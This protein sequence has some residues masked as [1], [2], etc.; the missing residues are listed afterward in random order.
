MVRSASRD[1][2]ERCQ[3]TTG[4][5]PP[6]RSIVA[7]TFQMKHV[8]ST[9]VSHDQDAV[10]IR[11]G[12]AAD[13]RWIC[14]MVLH[15]K[16][17]PIAPI[18]MDGFLLAVDAKDERLGCLKVVRASEYVELSSL[19]VTPERR[20]QGVAK[21]LVRAA[22]MELPSDQAVYL[23]TIPRSLGFWQQF[24]F[25]SVPWQGA[26]LPLV[27]EAILG[28]LVSRLVVGEP[29]LLLSYRKDGVDGD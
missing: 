1:V 27:A 24:G 7:R 14:T 5:P 3:A 21:K 18:S 23:T 19:I 17:N 28:N 26:P 2:S 25:Q 6:R 13:R 22:Q 16:M 15:E 9:R 10:R 20:R 29:C 8:A 4:S 12:T 11:P